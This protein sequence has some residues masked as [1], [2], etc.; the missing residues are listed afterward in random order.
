MMDDRALRASCSACGDER[1][2][3]TSLEINK[4]KAK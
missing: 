1:K 4:D 2:P 3:V